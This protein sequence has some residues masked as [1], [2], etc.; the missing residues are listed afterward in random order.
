MIISSWSHVKEASSF[1]SHFKNNPEGVLRALTDKIA[2]EILND[3]WCSQNIQFDSDLNFRLICRVIS[4]ICQEKLAL[5][6]V[7]DF[8][9]KLSNKENN[10]IFPCTEP[11][12][13]YPETKDR[14]HFVF[15]KELR[16]SLENKQ[17]H[18]AILLINS[19]YIQDED[20]YKIA[21]EHDCA[22]S[23]EALNPYDQ[24]ECDQLLRL[25]VIENAPRCTEL[26]LKRGANP[27]DISQTSAL[28]IAAAY[29]D[30]TYLELI[31]EHCRLPI[32][33]DLKDVDFQTPL[34]IAT[35]NCNQNNISFL[36]NSGDDANLFV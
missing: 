10:P 8:F 17:E 30:T 3:T 5:P 31:E 33:Y 1:Q 2:E 25:A 18:I 16:L 29:K 24:S 19:N 4:C 21:I 34:S 15:G 20:F 27:C 11:L 22:E 7:N 35:L 13:C 28:H 32:N 12:L 23:L 9:N 6:V 36:L 14:S 26:L